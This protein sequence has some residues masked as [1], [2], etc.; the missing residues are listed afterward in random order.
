M[1]MRLYCQNL[2]KHK[3]KY[4]QNISEHLIKPSSDKQITN[5]DKLC[6]KSILNYKEPENPDG[7]PKECKKAK[8]PGGFQTII[9]QNKEWGKKTVETLTGCMFSEFNPH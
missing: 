3:S 9:V 7:K 5:S 4:L 2:I 6:Y 8:T 1:K